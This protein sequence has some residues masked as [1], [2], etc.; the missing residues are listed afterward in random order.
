MASTGIDVAGSRPPHYDE[1]RRI[2]DEKKLHGHGD[3]ESP[4]IGSISKG[5]HTVRRL[6]SRHIQLIGAIGSIELR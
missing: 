2:S 5:D 4:E 1:P 3:P 6:K